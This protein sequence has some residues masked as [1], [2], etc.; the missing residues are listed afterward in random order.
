[1]KNKID[2]RTMVPLSLVAALFMVGLSATATGVFWVSKVNERLARIE[3]RLGIY[4]PI[5]DFSIIPNA[6]AE[7]KK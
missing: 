6:N 3:D 7:T 5:A 4:T 1:M 2:E